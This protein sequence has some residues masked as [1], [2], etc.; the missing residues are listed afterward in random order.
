MAS[1][2]PTG[3]PVIDFFNPNV[4]LKRHTLQSAPDKPKSSVGANGNGIA[5]P[6][7]LDWDEVPEEPEQ[8]EYWR[9]IREREEAAVLEQHRRDMD[10]ERVWSEAKPR[11]KSKVR[12]PYH[13]IPIFPWKKVLAVSLFLCQVPASAKGGLSSIEENTLAATF[14]R[15]GANAAVPAVERAPEP[16]L[17]A[18]YD[19]GSD[20]ASGYQGGR[21]LAVTKKRS[22]I[23]EAIAKNP[24]VVV[25]GHTG[26]GKTTQIPQFILDDARDRN[27]FVNIVVTQPRRIAAAS[28]AKRVARERGWQL[29]GLVGY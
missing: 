4:P 29:G 7:L 15:L 24:A 22:E 12:R 19:T 11:G 16:A 3:D 13:S 17:M 6:Q 9:P 10:P 25:H 23:L 2:K 8:P 26:C 18:K 21:S 14:S 1:K 5:K 20:M 27:K 28:V